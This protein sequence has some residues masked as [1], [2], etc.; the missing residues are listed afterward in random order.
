MTFKT[1]PA[2]ALFDDYADATSVTNTLTVLY[3]HT[4]AAGQLAANGDKLIARYALSLAGTA[5]TKQVR[6]LFAGA[7]IAGTATITNASA[8]TAFVDLLVVR[9]SSSVIRCFST[10]TVSGVANAAPLVD[11]TYTRLP[12]LTLSGTNTLVLY[13]QGNTGSNNGDITAVLGFVQYIAA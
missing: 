13:G 12:S 6:I 11:Q 9:E 2:T 4:L 8:A 1:P 10:V 3:T 7:D 5:F